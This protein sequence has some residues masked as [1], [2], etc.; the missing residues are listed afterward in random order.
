M[1]LTLERDG[2]DCVL[3]LPPHLVEKFRLNEGGEIFAT[4]NESGSLILTGSDPGPQP[5]VVTKP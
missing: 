5:P 3:I 1:K 4:V 2:D